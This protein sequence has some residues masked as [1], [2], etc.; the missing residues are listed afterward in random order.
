[1]SGRY[2]IW[3]A[4]WDAADPEAS[5]A[6]RDAWH[7]ADIRVFTGDYFKTVGLDVLQGR[8]PADVDM[9]AEPVAWVS[10][11]FADEVF[12]TLNP[13]AQRIRVQGVRRVV[14]VVEDVPVD[15]RGRVTRHVYLSHAQFNN[16][17]NWAL[18]QVV[19]ARGDLGTVRE[20]IRDVI[21]GLDPNLV[22]YR[23]R[24]LGDVVGTSRAQD[25]FATVLMGAF[26][27][28]ALVLS[29]VGTY[30]VLAGSV[31]GRRREIGIRMALG[32]DT[33]RVRGIVLR[34]AATLTI[35]GVV[36]GLL[37]AF[38]GSGLLGTLLF[39]VERGD[40]LAYVLA[41]AVFVGV[42]LLAGWVPARRAM[43]VDPARTLAEE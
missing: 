43:R 17:R 39:G 4:F 32:A 27:F 1:M 37:L 40:P 23:P 19:K 12:G 21:E 13:L 14:G 33:A 29:L 28:L 10:R 41:V 15:A 36:L 22:L 30:G 38:V 6:N 20:R 11:T 31:A 25:R 26:A 2:H 16:D 35:P 42:G 24:L 9:E 7:G 8:A 5:G 3:S 34:Y 18:I